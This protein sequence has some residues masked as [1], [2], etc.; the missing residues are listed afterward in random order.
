VVHGRNLQVLS[1]SRGYTW[2]AIIL[3]LADWE[4]S[5]QRRM[6]DYYNYGYDI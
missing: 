1:K 3:A 4:R 2:L 5:K 6:T